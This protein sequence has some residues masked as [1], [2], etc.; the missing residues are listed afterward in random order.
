MT[1]SL[2]H[3]LATHG[4][5]ATG[6]QACVPALTALGRRVTPAGGCVDAVHLLSWVI[7]AGQHR[8]TPAAPSSPRRR[9]LLACAGRERH[10]LGLEALHAVLADHGIAAR[11]LGPSVPAPALAAAAERTRPAAVVVWAQVSRTGGLRPLTHSARQVIAAGPGWRR[12][13]L[14]AGALRVD[15]LPVAVTAIRAAVRLDDR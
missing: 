6:Q 10:S 5:E 14:P 2:E 1:R 7:I 13:R 8:H 9:V 15:S 12:S 3:Q 11:M 4:L